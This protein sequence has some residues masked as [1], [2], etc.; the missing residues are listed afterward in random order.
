VYKTDSGDCSN[1]VW[2]VT[3]T[4]YQSKQFYINVR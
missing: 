3:P 1:P 4:P 2:P